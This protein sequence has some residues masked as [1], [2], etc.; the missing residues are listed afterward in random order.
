M[1]SASPFVNRVVEEV[2][3]H[4]HLSVFLAERVWGT[5]Y[6]FHAL[7]ERGQPCVWL[8]LNEEDEGDEVAAGNKLAAALS[9][10]FGT[11]VVG[12]GMPYDYVVAVLGQ[13]LG[14]LGPLTLILSGAEFAQGLAGVIGAPARGGRKSCARVRTS[15]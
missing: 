1:S 11:Q 2:N 9:R 5:P 10:A 3:A 6:I 12:Q 13:H 4:A 8:E 15:P 7:S 14:L